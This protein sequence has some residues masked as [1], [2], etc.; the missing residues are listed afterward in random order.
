MPALLDAPADTDYQQRIEQAETEIDNLRAAFGWSLENSEVELALALASSLQPLWHP[1]RMREGLTW[2][3]TALADLDAN[4]P[5]VT[6][7]VRARAL[8]DSAALGLWVGAADSPDRARQALAIA[9]EVDD[10]VLLARALTT[11]GLI[12]GYYDPEE[13]RGFFAEAIGL[14]R[15]SDDRWWLSQILAA[16][17]IIATIAGDLLALRAAAEEGRDLADALGDRLG[18]RTCRACLAFAQVFQ[19]NLAGAAAQFAEQLAEA[20]TAHDGFVE[21]TNLSYQSFALAF[22]GEAAAARA[23]ADAAVEAAAELGGLRA[24]VAYWASAT[25]A[26]AAGDAAAAQDATDAAWPHLRTRPQPAGLGRVCKAHAALA[27]GDLVAARRWADDAVTTTT[28][29]LLSDALTAR[30]RVATA[31]G[32]PN[33]AERDAHDALAGAAEAEAYLLIPDILEC[34]AAVAGESGSHREAARLFGAAHSIRQ[35]M[36][37]V[38]FKVW[39]VGCEASVA[40]LRDALGEHDFDSAWNEGAALST[41]EAIAYAQRGR[42]E[43]K[44]PASGWAS[45]TPTERDVVRLVSKGLANKDIAS[46]LFVSPRTVQTHLTHVYAKLGLNSRMQLL[47]EAA[48][49]N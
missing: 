25:T 23:A 26:L 8:A 11:C 22:R 46:R 14:A 19:G 49:H 29:A 10:P 32:E 20:R 34:L 9:R 15:A 2:F 31:Q 16:Q 3:D 33:Q 42:G 43:R 7:A 40:A 24:G 6:P 38:R 27:G 18:S 39:D 28:G 30:A 21:A 48:R 13:A 17:A 4:H 5:E 47:Q 12:A 36:G 35:R 41:E 37:A 44:R 1:R 45:L